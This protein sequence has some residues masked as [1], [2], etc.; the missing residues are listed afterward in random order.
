MVEAKVIVI[1]PIDSEGGALANLLRFLY[2]E[3]IHIRNLV[4][5]KA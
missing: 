2:L 1:E 5:L 4:E 3:P